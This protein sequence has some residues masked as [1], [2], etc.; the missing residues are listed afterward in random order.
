MKINRQILYAGRVQGVGFRYSVKQIATG[1]DV[2]G[3]VRNLADGR[4][5][6]QATGEAD[7]VEA[8]LAAVAGSHLADHIQQTEQTDIQTPTAET[9]AFEIRT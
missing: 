2:T 4:V 5:E 1:F 6:L 9:K 8:F 7:E 3:W